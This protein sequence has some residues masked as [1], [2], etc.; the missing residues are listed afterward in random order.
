MKSE[1]FDVLDRHRR[2]APMQRTVL[3]VSLAACLSLAAAAFAQD[4]GDNG[5]QQPLFNFPV[6]TCLET[7]CRVASG[8]GSL[9]DRHGACRVVENRNTRA[10]MVPTRTKE[11]WVLGAN[12]FL[13]RARANIYIH[14]CPPGTGGTDQGEGGNVNPDPG[15]PGV[16]SDSPGSGFD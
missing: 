16:G 3:N 14:L 9:I 15:T 8:A 10:V 5:Q 4:G 13:A 7:R 11:E 12:A 2:E 6:V 1:S